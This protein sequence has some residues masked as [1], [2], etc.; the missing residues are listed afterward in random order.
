MKEA[1]K[2]PIEMP[3]QEM[4]MSDYEMIRRPHIKVWLLLASS[5]NWIKSDIVTFH[6]YLNERFISKSRDV[7][8]YQLSLNTHTVFA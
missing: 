7:M 1:L 3:E 6:P 5:G 4:E 8:Y 2:K